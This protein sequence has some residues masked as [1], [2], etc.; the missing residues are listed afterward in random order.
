MDKD[1]CVLYGEASKTFAQHKDAIGKEKIEDLVNL[2]VRELQFMHGCD[3]DW[4]QPAGGAAASQAAVLQPAL[5]GDDDDA[6]ANAGGANGTSDPEDDEDEPMDFASIDP[7]DAVDSCRWDKWDYTDPSQF[8]QRRESF[9]VTIL[10]FF[11]RL[12]NKGF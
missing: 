4:N 8:V 2:C 1:L 9:A 3:V 5:D 10:F 6:G 12:C 11:M 7:A